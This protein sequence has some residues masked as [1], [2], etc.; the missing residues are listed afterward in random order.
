MG[1]DKLDHYRSILLER[2]K[3]VLETI[4]RLRE[5]SQFK[6]GEFKKYSDDLADMGSDSMGKEE[7]F[8]FISRELQYLF[9]IDN[10]L[11]SIN[12][13]RYGICKICGKEIPKARLELVPTTDSCINCKRLN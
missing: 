5:M 11:K 1:K 9:R 8:R 6:E 7:S 3:F 4:E 13:G 12:S 10:A 2:R